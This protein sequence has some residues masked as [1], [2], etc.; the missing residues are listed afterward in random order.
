MIQDFLDQFV[1]RFV[2]HPEVHRAVYSAW[3]GWLIVRV[4]NSWTAWILGR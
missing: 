1:Q 4:V 3:F 2:Q